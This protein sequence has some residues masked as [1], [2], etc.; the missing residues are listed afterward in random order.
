MGGVGRGLHCRDCPQ[1]AAD[2][3]SLALH[4]P[5]ICAAQAQFTGSLPNK[6]HPKRAG[7]AGGPGNLQGGKSYSLVVTDLSR[8][9]GKRHGDKNLLNVNLKIHFTSHSSVIAHNSGNCSASC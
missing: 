5:Q 3:V 1:P 8:H 4:S 6:L 2:G 7:S 9:R